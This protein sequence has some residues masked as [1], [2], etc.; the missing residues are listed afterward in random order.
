VAAIARP[1]DFTQSLFD[2]GAT[3]CTPRKPACGLCPWRDPCGARAEGRQELLPVKAPRRVRPI[4]YGA[5]FWLEDEAGL[6]LLRRRPPRGLLGGMLELP[7]TEWRGDVWSMEDA[8]RRAPQAA[9]WHPAGQAAHG[10]THFELRLDVYAARVV[11]I[12]AEGLP[13]RATGLDAAALPTVMR[14]CVTLGRA[15]HGCGSPR[16]KG[17]PA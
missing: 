17:S 12:V 3:I 9:E 10:F 16:V 13:H 5:A 14:R 4:R 11:S 7:G 8:K 15:C 2:L 6:V 1:A